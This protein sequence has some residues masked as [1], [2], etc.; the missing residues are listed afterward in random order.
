MEAPLVEF[1]EISDEVNEILIDE[2]SNDEE[3][4]LHNVPKEQGAVE[5]VSDGN[6]VI[7]TWRKMKIMMDL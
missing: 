5:D 7:Q 3:E 2:R 4:T 6:E 1:N